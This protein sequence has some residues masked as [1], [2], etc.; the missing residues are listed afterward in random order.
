MAKIAQRVVNM[1]TT[2]FAEINHYAAQYDTVNLGQGKPDYDG[3]REMLQAVADA[4][5][6]GKANQY[7]PG[8]GVP[9]LLESIA[10]HAHTH[11]NLDIDPQGGAVVTSGA[12]E[13]MYSAITGIVNPGD[14]VIL[15][16][17]FFDTY[18]P[19]IEWAGGVPVFVPMYPPQWTFDHDELRAKFTP[20]TRAIVLNSPHNPTGRVF[21]HEELKLIAELCQ[22]FDVIVISDEVYEHLTYD[23]TRH[24][25]IA[26]LPNMFERTIT[27]SSG[28]K[29]F[30]M[31]GWKIGWAMGH[32]DLI[33]GVW[34]IHQNVT[35]A[36]NHPAQ[37]GIAYGLRMDQN[38][39]DTLKAM[40]TRKRQI[41]MNG[42]IEAGIRVE[43]SPAGAF[44][45]MGDFSDVYDGTDREFARWLIREYGVACIPP[46]YFF[47]ETNAHLA[48]KHA[49]F[50]YCK[51]DDS[52]NRAV[53]RLA[54]LKG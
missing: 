40:Y 52:L 15:I 7:A 13:G 28:A 33:Q 46:S 48:Q 37:Y 41:L 27:V 2:I 12:S 24:I 36:V 4:M 49:R 26:T 47:S 39:Y 31:T 20:N 19:A 54:K 35:F 11:Y 44:Y 10:D 38:Y 9:A 5:L 8:F 6:S 1:S 21:T 25:P 29:T 14:E 45:I 17:P 32:P 18:L 53:D 16:E 3:P 23:G 22:E 34:R 51:N 30:S 50:S 42:L 43:Y